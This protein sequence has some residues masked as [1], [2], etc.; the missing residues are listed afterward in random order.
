MTTK[1]ISGRIQLI[2]D[3]ARNG[4]YEAAHAL[5]DQLHLDV[6]NAIAAG[7]SPAKAQAWA[8]AATATARIPFP[9]D[10]A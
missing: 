7:V 2:S 6:L 1:E 5:E 4:D 3:R 10:C 9:R 8:R